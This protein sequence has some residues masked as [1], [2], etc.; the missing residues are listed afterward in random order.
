MNLLARFDPGDAVTRVVLITLLQTSAVILSAA[1][2]GRTVLR[3]R[4]DARHSLWLAVLAWVT[5]SPG[6]SAIADRSELGL[7]VVD[8]P[9]PAPA[10]RRI[11]ADAALP[12]SPPYEG[13][14]RGGSGR[15]SPAL[16]QRPD[17]LRHAPPPNPPFVRGGENAQRSPDERATR[18]GLTFHQHGSASAFRGALALIWAAVVLAGL[19]RIV[20]GWRRLAEFTDMTRPLDP[21]R[22]G[23][24]LDR[25]RQALGVAT[26]PPIVTS[27]TAREPVAV[28]LLQPRVVL[29]EG[30]AEVA[31]RDV[32]RDVLIHE[33]AHVFRR[34]LWIGLVQRLVSALFWPHP[35]IHHVSSQLARA[36]EEVCDNHVLR[37]GDPCGYARTLLALTERYR[38]FGVAHPGLGLLGA[39][40]TL[41]DRIAGLLDPRRIP[42]TRT[43]IRMKIAMA[44]ALAA[45]GLTASTVRFDRPVRA[46][47]WSDAQAAPKAEAPAIPKTDIWSI[48][49]LVVDEQGRPVPGAIVHAEEEADPAGSKTAPDGSFALGMGPRLYTRLLLVEADDGARIGLVRFQPSR[50]LGAKDAVRLVLKPARTVIVRVQ[51]AVGAPVP[52]AAVE[53]FDYGYQFHATTAASGVATLRVPAD[54]RISGVIGLK[55]GAGFDYFENYRTTPPAPEFEFPPLPAELTL[56]LDGAQTVRIKVIGPNGQPMSGVAIKPFRPAK[57]G[58]ITTIAIARGATTGA[59]T[60]AQGIAVFDWLPKDVGGVTFFIEPPK[61]FSSSGYLRYVRGGPTELTTRV[62][63]GARL[64]GTIRFPDGRPARRILVIAGLTGRGWI[65]RG[66]RTDDEGKY[67]FDLGPGHP[68]MIA[69]D[70]ET[71]AAPS[72]TSTVL[73]EGQEQGG[74]DFT[75]SRGTLIHGQVTEVP[76]NRPSPGMM[77]SLGERGGPLPKELRT[78]S[79]STFQLTRNTYTDAQG[80][81]QIRV[82]PGRYSLRGSR[83]DDSERQ[84]V[85]VKNEAEIVHD[86]VAKGSDRETFLRGV[87]V[88][89][90]ETGERPI[91]GAWAFRWPVYGVAKTDAEGQFLRE[92]T[93]GETIIYAYCP[94]KG[95]AGFSR[96]LPGD[97]DNV[98][99]VLSPT[100]TVTGRVIDSNG[101]PRARQQVGVRLSSGSASRFDFMVSAVTTDDQGR[102]TYKDAPPGSTGELLVSH[103]KAV[104]P[105][106]GPHTVVPFEVRDLDP[107]QLPDLVVPADKPDK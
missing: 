99:V 68:L 89:K 91:S 48:E 92:R 83:S 93:P 35:L 85:E 3:R 13:G 58:K 64:T 77:V 51:D 106:A 1:L 24:A 86:L 101:K 62:Q 81:Y 26:L 45:A 37:C 102:F 34:D 27:P 7:W 9:L 38:P 84:A 15:T 36:R 8:L 46:D 63:R 30:L 33:C 40:W 104:R 76:E 73:Q 79:A 22:H 23:P 61:G 50:H 80:H 2:L 28:G 105:N 65:P 17:D 90:T 47:E 53:A 16:A 59:T 11:I 41:A 98:K 97:A 49:G 87:V 67:A 60:D 52:G 39:R 72:L 10:V 88:Q 43:T 54:A 66:A 29:P 4:A 44:L 31:S 78:V 14:V 71:W 25:V 70:D 74:L 82:A 107:I 56:T 100:A 12:S 21:L 57:P 55:S 42:M 75:L 18:S 6:V 94:D 96:I 32:L 20:A 19:A 5:I 103:Q 69:V 95:L